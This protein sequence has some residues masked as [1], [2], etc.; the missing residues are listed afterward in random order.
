MGLAFLSVGAA[1]QMIE[2]LRSMNHPPDLS[3]LHHVLTLC[4]KHLQDPDVAAQ[5][6]T[7]KR[8]WHRNGSQ[9][10]ARCSSDLVNG[11]GVHL[12]QWYSLGTRENIDC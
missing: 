4:S 10:M 6:G 9:V 1:W 12:V 11:T 3:V 2:K 8:S 7:Y 5:V